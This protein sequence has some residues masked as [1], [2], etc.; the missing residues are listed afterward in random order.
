MHTNVKNNTAILIYASSYSTFNL[1]LFYFTNIL[2][3]SLLIFH[4][5][6]LIHQIEK[7]RKGKKKERKQYFKNNEFLICN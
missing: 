5:K 6:L 7:K 2:K 4:C 1:I 3:K